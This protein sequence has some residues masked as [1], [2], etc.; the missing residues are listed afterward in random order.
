[1][2]PQSWFYDATLALLGPDRDGFFERYKFDVVPATDDRPYFFHFFKWRTL[3]EILA[4]KDRGGLPLL[5][6]GYPV[7]IAA[8]VQAS[9]IGV[10]LILLPLIFAAGR[11]RR[12]RAKC[13]AAR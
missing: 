4:L 1:V 7:L 10:L 6:W 2:L 3:P 8:F 12:P 9:V 11:S 5:E 13:R